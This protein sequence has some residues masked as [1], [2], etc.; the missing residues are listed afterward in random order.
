MSFCE[1]GLPDGHDNLHPVTV[2]LSDEEYTRLESAAASF[3]TWSIGELLQSAL[4]WVVSQSNRTLWDILVGGPLAAGCGHLRGKSAVSDLVP[5][6]SSPDSR[7]GARIAEAAAHAPAEIDRSERRWHQRY[8]LQLAVYALTFDAPG[9]IV[10]GTTRNISSTGFLAATHEP[11]PC[12][13]ALRVWIA[14]PLKSRRGAPLHLTARG[15]IVWRSGELAG[16]RVHSWDFREGPLPK[17]YTTI[18]G[19]AATRESA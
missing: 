8:D 12:K 15:Q 7:L 13:T 11:P 9:R 14:W 18:P 1:V 16:V 17:E 19:S 5:S 10:A 2:N 3:G 4:T 6:I